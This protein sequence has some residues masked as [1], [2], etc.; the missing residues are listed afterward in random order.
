[1]TG[2]S[3]GFGRSIAGDPRLNMVLDRY[4][5]ERGKP[6]TLR[7]YRN[8][9]AVL[10]GRYQRQEWEVR[11]D[12]CK[13]KGIPTVYRPTGGGALYTDPG[14]L[15][16][17]LVIAAPPWRDEGPAG[18]LRRFA[19]A[20]AEAV[21]TLGIG[22]YHRALNDVEVAGRKIASAYAV[23]ESDRV[24]FQGCLLLDADVARMLKALRVPTEKLTTDGLAGARQRLTTVREQ[25]GRERPLEV[26]EEAVE[27]AM[28]AHFELSSEAGS[29]VQRNDSVPVGCWV[30]GPKR[31]HTQ[32]VGGGSMLEAAWREPGGVIR[33]RIVTNT[34][35]QIARAVVFG[36]FFTEP[37]DI[38][39]A[40]AYCLKGQP[41]REAEARTRAFLLERRPDIPGIAHEALVHAVRLAVQREEERGLLGLTA[42]EAN[43]LMV[44]GP[45][46][47]TACE[48]L[49]RVNTL[50]VPYCAKATWC[51][52]RYRDGC[53]D[54]GL[55]EVGEAYRLG[56]ERMLRVTSIQNYEHLQA[57][58][59][60]LAREGCRGLVGMCC[61][62]FFIKRHQAFRDAGIPMVLLD[63]SGSNCYELGQEELAYAGTFAAKATLD[64]PVLRRVLQRV[65]RAGER[66]ADA[67]CPV[68][69]VGEG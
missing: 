49:P 10:L 47:E 42:E 28:R 19:G 60:A 54:C 67:E 40:L 50:L 6:D 22:C 26:V 58:L 23:S 64:L 30:T 13:R 31:Q 33:V 46:G 36:D 3:T 61:H 17:S 1:M 43:R 53:P 41:L 34:R 39:E 32:P 25:L 15:W 35:G 21:Q 7:L 57:V 16:V 68:R 62:N 69:K 5:L 11:S 65:S 18:W 14:Q 29:S 27:A 8:Q 20:L 37:P 38:L 12:Y 9:P 24:L 44:V 56:R 52:W 55:C 63:I 66:P 48:I 2:S 59:G 51:K 45:S 4:R